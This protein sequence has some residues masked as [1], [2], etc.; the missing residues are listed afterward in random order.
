VPIGGRGAFELPPA[1][2]AGF[3][4]PPDTGGLGDPEDD[5]PALGRCSPDGGGMPRSA[6]KFEIFSTEL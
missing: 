6:K 3:E 5:P 4:S 2:A 1:G